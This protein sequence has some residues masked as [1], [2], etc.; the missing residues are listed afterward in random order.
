M[1]FTFL[2]INHG[3]DVETSLPMVVCANP[4]LIAEC[5]EVI[6]HGIPIPDDPIL[7]LKQN[8]LKQLL[9]Q[10]KQEVSNECP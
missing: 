3:K 5:C 4:Q 8:N 7:Q 1:S 9:Q 6:I 2:T 10:I